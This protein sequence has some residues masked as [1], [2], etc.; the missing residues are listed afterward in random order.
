MS[1]PVPRESVP[2]RQKRRLVAALALLVFALGFAAD[3][4]AKAWALA[5][6]GDSAQIPLLPTVSFRLAF[7]PG[8]AFSMGAAAGPIVPVGIL[9]VLSGLTAWMVWTIYSRRSMTPTLFLAAAAAGGWGNM[10]DRF[11]RADNGPLS[12][13]VVDYIAVDWFS[14]FNGA[15]ILAVGGILGYAV[16]TVFSRDARELAAGQRPAAGGSLPP[17]GGE[18]A[19]TR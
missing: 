11:S 7:N 18:V 10:W 9:I 12:G 13:A 6:L 4:G 14:I 16:V 3:Q 5:Y 19:E 8:M 15:D 17:G 1:L 2:G